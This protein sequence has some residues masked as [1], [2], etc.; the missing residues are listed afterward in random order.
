MITIRVEAFSPDTNYL[1]SAIKA[2]NINVPDDCAKPLV[3]MLNY[4]GGESS[5][6]LTLDCTHGFAVNYDNQVEKLDKLL[7]SEAS[8]L[9]KHFKLITPDWLLDCI[10]QNRIIDEMSYHPKYL[11][12]NPQNEEILTQLNDDQKNQLLKEDTTEV[13]QVTE[14][15]LNEV[16]AQVATKQTEL[17]AESEKQINLIKL[18]HYNQNQQQQLVEKNNSLL[19]L[20]LKNLEETKNKI[21]EYS[22][23]DNLDELKNLSASSIQTQLENTI[24]F[25]Q[26]ADMTC[27]DMPSLL[28][29]TESQLVNF[30]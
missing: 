14:T 7:D 8:N 12:I 25:N 23:S 16:E 18:N 1:F 17:P 6:E 26:I 22:C 27:E 28:L 5:N 24:R 15:I 10:N 11:I 19:N 4:Y 13:S 3:A 9:G 21:I 30:I 20:N 29:D 2:I